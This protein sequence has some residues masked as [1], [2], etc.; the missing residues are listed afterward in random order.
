MNII[1]TREDL[2]ATLGTSDYDQ[3]MSYLRGSM[4]R[5]ENQAVYPDDYNS[6]EYTGDVVEPV[7]VEVEDLSTI[8]RFGF[9]KS[10]FN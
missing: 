4:V 3:F 6:S 7:W 8:E 1:N 2:D 9:T 10:D 5:L